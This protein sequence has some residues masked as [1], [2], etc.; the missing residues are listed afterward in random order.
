MRILGENR[1]LLETVTR[2][3]LEVEVMEGEEL[4]R[5]LGMPPRDAKP[6]S[7]PLPPMTT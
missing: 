2:R 5:L 7:V 1:G 6:D 4:L 3:L